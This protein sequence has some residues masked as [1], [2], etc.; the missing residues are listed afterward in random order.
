[1]VIGSNQDFC[2][3][4]MTTNVVSVQMIIANDDSEITSAGM[5]TRINILLE[6]NSSV[7]SLEV[8]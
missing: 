4:S 7:F 1:M 8:N 6:K 3:R 5:V 2:S